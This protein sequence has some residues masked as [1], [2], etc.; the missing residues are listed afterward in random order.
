MMSAYT[1]HRPLGTGRSFKVNTYNVKPLSNILSVLNIRKFHEP[2]FV[3]LSSSTLKH[4]KRCGMVPN[5]NGK[6]CSRDVHRKLHEPK[7]NVI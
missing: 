7:L 5:L 1:L 6:L 2:L 3:Q 4:L